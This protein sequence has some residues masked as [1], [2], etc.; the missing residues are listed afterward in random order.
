MC[1]FKMYSLKCVAASWITLPRHRPTLPMIQYS[2][3]MCCTVS[4]DLL[5]MTFG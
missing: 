4:Y 3:R 2:R 5:H 1:A